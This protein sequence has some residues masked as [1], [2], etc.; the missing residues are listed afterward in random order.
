MNAAPPA[1]EAVDPRRERAIDIACARRAMGHSLAI[2]LSTVVLVALVDGLFHG[3]VPDAK[4][5][6]WSATILVLLLARLV[7]ALLYARK[8]PA[9]ADLG[10]WLVAHTVLL[11]AS[12]IVWGVLIFLAAPNDGVAHTTALVFIAG[13]SAGAS[14]SL[15][16]TPK[17]F[18]AILLCLLGPS[19]FF[20][21][22]SAVPEHRYL[23]LTVLVYLLAIANI[24]NKNYRL[25]RESISLRFGNLDLVERLTAA[26]AAKDRF[27]AAASHDIRQPV[28]AAF[29]FLGA[30]E[31]KAT[32]EQREVVDGLRVSLVSARQMLDALLDVSKLD[33][34]V[35]ER[36]D[37]PCSA[38][39]LAERLGAL[40]AP[41]AERKGLSLRFR[42]PADL[43]LETDATLLHSVLMNLAG[44]ALA[45]TQRGGVL[46]AFRRRKGRCIVQV[47]DTGIGIPEEEH[48]AIFEEFKQLSN[49]ERD[50]SRGIGLGLSIVRRLCRLLGTEVTLR[51]RVGRGSVFALDLPIGAAP[52]SA[53]AALPERPLAPRARL[54]VV[55]DHSIVRQG[56]CALL[57]AWG[58]HVVTAACVEEACRVV[59]EDRAIDL[60]LVDY[61]L[62]DEKTGID[63]IA[64][65]EATLGRSIP[66]VIITG[67]TSPARI[68]EASLGG[69]PV[70]FKPLPPDV[71]KSALESE[72]LATART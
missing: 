21:F 57:E 40:L 17:T 41:I 14:Q 64:A 19:L 54:L 67:D 37:G 66:A 47:W 49:P 22:T 63:A 9:D 27:L 46:V 28:H 61:R 39:A 48:E 20:F 71:L 16:G 55:D 18:A 42:A 3:R 32:A 35:V 50:T 70:V 68:R 11:T 44:N 29:L 26:T 31:Q 10:G 7:T 6:A 65:I 13:H 59:A 23:G 1:G 38:A 60:A 52:A 34:G 24:G 72:L 4:L 25:L 43:W 58:Y 56:L 15:I 30:L 2:L 36:T 33:A 69:R 53:S 8:Q 45:Y 12:S 51:S 62:P 5:V